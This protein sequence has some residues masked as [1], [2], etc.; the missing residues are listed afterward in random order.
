MAIT[1]ESLE[2]EKEVLMAV[3]KGT[4]GNGHTRYI[5]EATCKTK[6]R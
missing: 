6:E 3:N 5:T 2:P 4:A 1:K